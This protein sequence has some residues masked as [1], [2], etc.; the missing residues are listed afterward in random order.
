MLE[1]EHLYTHFQEHP[2][3]Y[4]SSMYYIS[5]DLQTSWIFKKIITTT[6][7]LGNKTYSLWKYTIYVQIKELF[8]K[9]Q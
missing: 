1:L 3:R 7:M 2:P 5:Q 4:E 6:W 9:F 8:L